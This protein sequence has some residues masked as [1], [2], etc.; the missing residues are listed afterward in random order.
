MTVEN[1][2][3]NVAKHVAWLSWNDMEIMAVMATSA[4]K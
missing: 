4:V 2:D 3:I 1:G